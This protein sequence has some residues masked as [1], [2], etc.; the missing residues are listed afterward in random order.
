[1][2][3]H[4]A[5]SELTIAVEPLRSMSITI[6]VA[7]LLFF[8]SG[9]LVGATAMLPRLPIWVGAVFLVGYGIMI[10]CSVSVL[11]WNHGSRLEIA[12]VGDR[13]SW[14]R[15]TLG[16]RR[17]HSVPQ[18]RI[19]EISIRRE[20]LKNDPIDYRFSG[21]GRWSV[22]LRE[23]RQLVTICRYLTRSD[24]S[25]LAQALVAQGV[26]VRTE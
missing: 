18:G 11:V 10:G 8:V 5:D 25:R 20:G 22:T 16:L 15:S 4:Q 23:D 17:S 24:A 6:I 2:K 13:F 12:M 1:M 19:E 21:V 14:T 7:A 3:V 9:L 26:S